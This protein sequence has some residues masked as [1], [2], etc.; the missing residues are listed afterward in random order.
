MT[1]V[2][3]PGLKAMSKQNLSTIRKESSTS[4]PRKDTLPVT[5]VTEES[6][7]LRLKVPKKS[8]NERSTFSKPPN[9]RR[10]ES[11]HLYNK[12]PT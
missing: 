9:Q 3:S 5:K 2:S 6:N 4:N 11:F 12:S 8:D 1:S 10:N 7:T